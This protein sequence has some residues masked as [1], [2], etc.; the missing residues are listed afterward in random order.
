MNP[1]L[2]RA[3]KHLGQHFL[4]DHNIASKIVD[5]L[6][7]EKC[8]SV[9]EIGPGTGILTE[10]LI[11]KIKELWLI[12]I[13]IESVEFLRE[14]FPDLHNKIVFGDFLKMEF[15]ASFP[16]EF[17]IIGNFPY[18]ISSQIFFRILENRDRIPHV[19]CMIQKEV[20]ERI[21]SSHGSK[22][23][24]ILSVLLQS[25]YNIDYLFTV[26]EHVFDPPPK[27]KS[28]VI[29]LTRNQRKNLNCSEDLFFK[30][31]KMAFNQRRKMLRNSLKPLGLHLPDDN[32]LFSKRP[33]QLSVD[34][35]IELTTL[36]EK[37]L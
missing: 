7:S 24:G 1:K 28:A 12:E 16:P 15:P 20:A 26:S 3:K 23:Y 34:E 18:N 31:V 37:L 29:C 22:V 5:Q 19:V 35:L 13:D 2:I 32:S 6:S 14:K 10:F 4:K 27:V 33:E 17:C 30:V 9:L 11:K 36:L 21:A 8:N 25:Y